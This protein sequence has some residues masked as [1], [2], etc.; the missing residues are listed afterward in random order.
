MQQVMV[1][2]KYYVECPDC[3]EKIYMDWTDVDYGYIGNVIICDY[4]QCQMKILDIE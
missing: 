3:L 1:R 2:K 4:C